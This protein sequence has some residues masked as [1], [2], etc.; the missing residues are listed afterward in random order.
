MR[1]L[2]PLLLLS[3]QATGYRATCVDGELL[4]AGHCV[5]SDEPVVVLGNCQEWSCTRPP[6]EGEP[7]LVNGRSGYRVVNPNWGNWVILDQSCV[8]GD[9]GGAVES[10]DGCYLGMPVENHSG[11]CYAWGLQ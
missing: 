3:C 6:I 5:G 10:T 11:Q 7:V 4:T 2:L 9:S 8:P 1:R